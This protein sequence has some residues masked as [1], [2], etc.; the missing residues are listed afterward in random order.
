MEIGQ[1][2]AHI[3]DVR[4]KLDGYATDSSITPPVV[5]G[6][7]VF[8]RLETAEVRLQSLEE[9]FKQFAGLTDDRLRRIEQA[10]GL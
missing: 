6:S 7:T 4:Q 2:Q 10:L 5:Q 9:G 1:Y 3:Q 8:S